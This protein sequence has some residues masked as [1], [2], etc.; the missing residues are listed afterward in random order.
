MKMRLKKDRE[1]ERKK[2]NERTREKEN[3]EEGSERVKYPTKRLQRTWREN[4]L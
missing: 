1:M 3:W 4:E 2:M